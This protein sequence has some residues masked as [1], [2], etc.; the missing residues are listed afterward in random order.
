MRDGKTSTLDLA[1][2]FES[3]IDLHLEHFSESLQVDPIPILDVK[4]KIEERVQPIFGSKSPKIIIEDHLSARATASSKRIRLR[5]GA[6][7]T[8]KDVDQLIN[9]E[10]FYSCCYNFKW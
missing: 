8:N 7:F 6:S 5:K 3:L 2:K 9:H 10:A 4:K 1:E